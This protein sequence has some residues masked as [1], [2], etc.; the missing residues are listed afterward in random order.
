MILRDYFVFLS[1][2]KINHKGTQR[3]TLRYTKDL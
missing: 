3:V 2:K 1:G